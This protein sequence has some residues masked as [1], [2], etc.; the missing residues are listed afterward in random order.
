MSASVQL[1]LLG[2][3]VSG[4]SAC[5]SNSLAPSHVLTAMGVADKLAQGSL[6]ISL[7]P[8]NTR[9]DIEAFLDAF[10]KVVA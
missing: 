6:R 5:S 7:G 10:R 9:E 8:Q 1:D 4:G 2:V 3:C